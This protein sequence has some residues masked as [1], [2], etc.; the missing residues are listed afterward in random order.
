MGGVSDTKA[1][2]IRLIALI[3]MLLPALPPLARA[4]EPL[5][6][7][8]R[9]RG[10]NDAELAARPAVEVEGIALST[11]VSEGRHL[12]LWQNGEAIY[13]NATWSGGGGAEPELPERKIVPGDRLRVSGRVIEG[14]FAPVIAPSRIEWLSAGTLPEPVA[15]NLVE[16]LSGRLASQWVRVEGVVQ[17][18]KPFPGI[19]GYW[20]MQVGTPYGRFAL[21]LAREEGV[22]PEEWIDATVSVRGVCLHLFNHRGEPVGVR[23]HANES[24]D[25]KV[26]SPAPADPFAVPES[27]L[28]RLQPFSPVEAMPHRRKIS[29]TATLC[30]PGSHLYLQ[31]GSRGLKVKTTSAEVFLPG[32]VV[33]ASGFVTPGQHYHEVHHAVVRKVGVGAP[34]EPLRITTQWPSKAPMPTEQPPFDDIHGR[35][36]EL[37]GLLEL[38]G[39]D[40]DGEWLSVTGEG[41]A[42]QV[43][44]NG[45]PWS[46]PRRGSLVRLTGVCELEYPVGDLVETF[47]RPTGMRLLPR[48]AADLVV[49]K[50]ASWWTPQRLW[51][52]VLGMVGLLA[53]AL[54]WVRTLSHRVQQRGA[55][56]AIEISGRRMAEA[57]T[58]ERTRMA[59]ELHDTIAQGLTGVSLQLGAANRALGQRAAELPRHLRLA[60]EILDSTRDEIR[61]T[62]WSLRSGLLDTGDLVGSLE[63][64]ARNLSPGGR[65]EIV[66]RST[67]RVRTLPDL[68]A[69]ALLRIAQEAMS[70]AVSHSGAGQVELVLG[71]NPGDVTLEVIDAGCGF[72]TQATADADCRHFGLQGMR[73]R[74]VRLQG[75]FEIQ[76]APGHGTRIHVRIPCPVRDDQT[77]SPSTP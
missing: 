31:K 42:V 16:M 73:G 39:R 66:C 22:S 57:R 55:E 37:T 1:E 21:R 14:N 71:F 49:L 6:S 5:R 33:E 30:V 29:G 65:P 43:R 18:V 74:V 12:L 60:G 48:G 58:E 72:D 41:A 69:H 61:R 70:N 34:P 59:E 36:V 68:V 15:T 19:D 4:D 77:M 51:L 11:L 8:A 23:I 2:L 27:A 32:D 35:L 56:L 38:T 45:G 46:I 26:I 3:W 62:L 76:S 53:L 44:L 10:L 75:D 47:N 28:E 64:I 52:L 13:V 63:A 54:A 24:A 50:A 20:S 40:V 7:I 67:G 25:V 9:L 17:A